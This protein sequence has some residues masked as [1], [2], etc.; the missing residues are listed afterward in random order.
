MAS[1]SDSYPVVWS[2]PDGRSVTGR[3]LAG[4]VALRLQGSGDGR[5]VGR[6]FAY[7]DL[8]GVRIGRSAPERLDGRPALVVEPHD[9]AAV[10]VRP[11][12]PGL[13]HELADLLAEL[14]ARSEPLAQV[15]VVLPL[16][17]GA[18]ATARELVSAGPPFDPGD[19]HL[20]RHEIFLTE[21]E[22]IFVFSGADACDSVRRVM[23]ESAVWPLADRWSV[24]LA[25]P[26]R[27]AE[28]GYSW[29]PRS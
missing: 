24:C 11:L 7:R 22:A 10:L 9:G 27:L 25:G 15:A 6:T 19:V 20:D 4:P 5:L 17:P 12:G 3:L 29:P 8:A 2:E 28:A 14:C 18:L 23:R 1:P 13:L 16:R 21:Q 26:P